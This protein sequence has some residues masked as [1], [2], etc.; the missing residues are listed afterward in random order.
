MAMNADA[1]VIGSALVSGLM[2]SAHCAAMCGGIATG[3]AVP[4]TRAGWLQ[5]LQPNLGRLLGYAAMGAVAG[6]FGH[7]I[8]SVAA[9][10][11]VAQVLR[12]AV[13][14]VLL[15]VALRLLDRNGR[16]A[17][18]ALPGRFAARLFAPLSRL[19]PHGSG[20]PRRL[21]A[22]LLWGLLPCGLSSTVLLAAWLQAS[23]LQ[24]GLTMLAFGIGT[25]PVML[26]LSWS[27]A[28]L[29]QWLDRAG[30][31]AAAGALVMLAGVSTLAAPWLGLMPGAHR[32]LTALGCRSL[33]VH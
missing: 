6:G 4:G 7:G 29:G 27:G 3:F 19:A 14:L 16:H 32:I 18:L 12:A 33:G 30:W 15:V 28:R 1:L 10:Q 2:G 17:Y 21:V 25:L 26:P 13:G 24:G 5:A 20:G 8:V 9:A 31:R 11:P 23:A 22:G